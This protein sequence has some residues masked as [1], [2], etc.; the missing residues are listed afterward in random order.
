MW[1]RL[2]QESLRLQV[3][4]NRLARDE[5]VHASVSGWPVLVDLRIQREDGDHG[6]LVPLRAGV[7]VEVMRA[8]D[9]HAAAAE[10]LV[11]K[12]IGNHR[13][14]AVTQW[15]VHHLADQVFVAFIV[16]MH[17]QRAIGQH[18]LRPRRGNVHAFDD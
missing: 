15:Q 9:F 2:L 4:Q 13:N 12:I 3:F 18:R 11:H 14:L 7:V 17:G 10:V 16:W 6:Q 8:G 5:P 1:H